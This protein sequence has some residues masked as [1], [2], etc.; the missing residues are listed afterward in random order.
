MKLGESNSEVS[1]MSTNIGEQVK[2]SL[3][4]GF[5]PLKSLAKLV[6][7]GITDETEVDVSRVKRSPGRGRKKGYEAFKIDPQ[8]ENLRF[9]L[10]N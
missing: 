5:Q 8:Q 9:I 6:T 10:Q 1:V 4:T 3:D 7:E 2:P